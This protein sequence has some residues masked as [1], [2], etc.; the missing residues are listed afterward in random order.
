MPMI[1]VLNVEE[2][3][4]LVESARAQPGVQVGGGPAGYTRISSEGQLHFNRKVLGFKPA[5]WYGALTGG[6][7]GRIVEFSRDDLRIEEAAS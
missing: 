6:L 2:F 3:R 7:V 1:F 4:P 5:V